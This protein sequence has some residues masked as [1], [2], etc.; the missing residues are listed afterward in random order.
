MSD[1]AIASIMG[2]PLSDFHGHIRSQAYLPQ[3]Y[4]GNGHRRSEN[5]WWA[6]YIGGFCLAAYGPFNVSGIALF[7][8]D[9]VLFPEKSSL[10]SLVELTSA[11]KHCVNR[12]PRL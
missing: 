4:G 12:F 1:F 5:V 8:R 3:R 2:I 11:W 6:A 10:P 9:D 7:L